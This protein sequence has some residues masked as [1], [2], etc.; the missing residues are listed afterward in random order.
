MGQQDLKEINS[1]INLNISAEIERRAQ[2]WLVAAKGTDW[3]KKFEDLAGEAAALR[4]GR[5]AMLERIKSLSDVLV[6]LLEDHDTECD[7]WHHQV[8]HLCGLKDGEK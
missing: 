3:D 4:T 7:C 8:L 6:E 1:L 5:H 2:E